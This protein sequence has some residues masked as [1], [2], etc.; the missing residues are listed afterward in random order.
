MTSRGWTTRTGAP[1]FARQRRQQPIQAQVRIGLRRR[2]PG[3]EGQV[4]PAHAS[5]EALE[6]PLLHH[7]AGRIP[8]RLAGQHEF[9][10]GPA[11]L[12][13][14]EDKG[15]QERPCPDGDG[16]VLPAAAEGGAVVKAVTRRVRVET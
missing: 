15:G 4:R 13:R 12:A 11:R 8:V 14:R 5:E 10:E 16:P 7:V 3:G 1:A 9:V 6:E 2:L